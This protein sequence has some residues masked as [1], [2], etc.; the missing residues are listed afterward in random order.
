MSDTDFRVAI[1]GYG[2]AGALFH[3]PLIAATPGL[4]VA[5]IVTR[6]SARRAQAA[7]DFPQATLL[8]D[9]DALWADPRAYDLVVV[10]A[11]N[12]AHLSLG[13]AALRAGIPTVI[14]KPLAVTVADAAQLIALSRE[15]GTPLTVYQ[16]RRWDGDFRT[17]RQL[18]ASNLLGPIVRF[19]SRYERWRTTPRAG[20]WREN[21]DPSE[22]GGL[23][24]DL[25]SH[26]IDQAH[27]LFGTPERVYA[28]V[29]TVRPNALVDDETFVALTFPGDLV[30][31][32]WMSVMVR[33]PGPRL[34]LIGRQGIFEK[35]GMD[36]QEDQLHAGLRPGAP[37]WG[38]E[39]T[40]QY[41]TLTTDIA[42]LDAQA[43]ITTLPGAYESFYA[44][45]QAA[46]AGTGSWPVDPAD[47]LLT[48]RIIAAAQQSARTAQVVP[49]DTIPSV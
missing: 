49:L 31:H 30:A 8:D 3:A 12:R 40:G 6:D 27:V 28:E 47:A 21:A 35:F 17:V 43:R 46:L 42:G 16:N 45:V 10:G 22:G 26:L 34:R 32:L 2:L 13:S 20:A 37:G 29:R 25:G 41:G 39:P 15:T 38:A 5:A 7:Q 19:E 23:L 9:A 18:I 14:D 48:T 11:P 24:L 33:V 36:A 4:Q 44:Q 1:I